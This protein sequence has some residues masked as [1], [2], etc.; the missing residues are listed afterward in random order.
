M[1][2]AFSGTPHSQSVDLVGILNS[3]IPRPIL[4]SNRPL[5]R[6]IT[7]ASYGLCKMSNSPITT[8]GN[9]LAAADERFYPVDEGPSNKYTELDRAIAEAT[10][11]AQITAPDPIKS[12]V[13]ESLQAAKGMLELYRRI[14]APRPQPD[15]IHALVQKV[16]EETN[17]ILEIFHLMKAP[18]SAS[19]EISAQ[20]DK[21]IQACREVDELLQE[22][23]M[24]LQAEWQAGMEKWQA[25][26]KKWQADME[27]WRKGMSSRLAC[28]SIFPLIVLYLFVFGS[29]GTMTES[30]V[31]LI[32]YITFHSAGTLVL[33]W[34][35]TYLMIVQN[36]STTG[37]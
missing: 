18:N 12:L 27:K 30:F 6:E 14:Q 15:S 1:Q 32:F 4:S 10:I 16:V 37:T 24:A 20:V 33:W 29:W 34:V 22:T 3:I 26:M 23:H 36:W 31:A 7:T 19:S 9:S 13:K 21:A 8:K 11:E 2:V 28:L 17:E 5:S 25:E 35:E